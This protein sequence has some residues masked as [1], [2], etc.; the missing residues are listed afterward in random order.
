M[1]AVVGGLQCRIGPNLLSL[2][3]SEMA[4]S[5]TLYLSNVVLKETRTSTTLEA[6]YFEYR[7]QHF[8]RHHSGKYSPVYKAQVWVY[9]EAAVRMRWVVCTMRSRRRWR[10]NYRN[11]KSMVEKK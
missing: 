5:V 1:A 10:Q 7:F 8:L 3:G 6:L 4:S 2:V 9:E 11:L